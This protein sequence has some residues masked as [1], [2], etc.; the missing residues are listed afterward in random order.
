MNLLDRAVKHERFGTYKAIADFLGISDA[1]MSQI[2]T[3]KRKLQAKHAALLSTEINEP[4]LPNIIE[5]LAALEQK[6][7]DSEFWLGKARQ[8]AQTGALAALVG[9]AGLM[10]IEGAKASAEPEAKT[11]SITRAITCI[12]GPNGRRQPAPACG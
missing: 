2:K 10:P 4:L 7:E 5:A 11:W 8:L 3:G 1:Y 9:V 6:P 12:N